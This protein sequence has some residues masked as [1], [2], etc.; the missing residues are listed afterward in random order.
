MKKE[1]EMLSLEEIRAALI[2]FCDSNI[3]IY[4]DGIDDFY[5]QLP[6]YEK[7]PF[8]KFKLEARENVLIR[9]RI[10]VG[11]M[12]YIQSVCVDQ[13]I[14]FLESQQEINKK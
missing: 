14:R 5:K 8:L 4:G 6:W 1:N 3:V 12:S 7:I 11:F 9:D 2:S 10:L 13:Y